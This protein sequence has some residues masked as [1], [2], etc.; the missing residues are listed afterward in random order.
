M[1]YDSPR[2]LPSTSFLT[3]LRAWVRLL[4]DAT[5]SFHGGMSIHLR[6]RQRRMTEQLLHRA[7]IGARVQE[8]GGEAVAQR[9]HVQRGAA[10]QGEKQP[11]QRELH[12][13]RRQRA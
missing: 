1:R 11:A 4:I 6:R 8:M 5:Q 12:A 9:M 10:R 7:E 2:R 3:Q 13:T